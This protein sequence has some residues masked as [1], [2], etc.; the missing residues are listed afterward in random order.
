[1]NANRQQI[2]EGV[3]VGTWLSNIELLNAEAETCYLLAV[4]GMVGLQ[5]LI[6]R[7]LKKS[8]TTWILQLIKS[9]ETEPPGR[10]LRMCQVSAHG[11]FGLVK[12]G[13]WRSG[14]KSW[15][16]KRRVSDHK[17][18]QEEKKRREDP[19]SGRRSQRLGRWVEQRAEGVWGPWPG[20]CTAGPDPAFCL[21][22]VGQPRPACE[23]DVGVGGD[24]REKELKSCQVL[25]KPQ[26]PDPL[27]VVLYYV[28]VLIKL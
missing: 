20:G 24:D 28:S 1:M 6:I 8:S 12:P 15:S 14:E 27:C 11:P 7:E 9:C 10:R 17:W 22:I 2:I 19:K 18:S 3:C 25:D 21:S 13:A 16:Q 5:I 23:R 4:T 26:C